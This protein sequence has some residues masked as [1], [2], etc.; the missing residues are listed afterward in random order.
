MTFTSLPSQSNADKHLT[1]FSP[2]V[3]ARLAAVASTQQVFLWA[4]L[5]A[6]AA[7]SDF[8]QGKVDCTTERQRRNLIESMT[9]V[10]V[11]GDS[12]DVAFLRAGGRALTSRGC[13]GWCEEALSKCPVEKISSAFQ[14]VHQMLPRHVTSGVVVRVLRRLSAAHRLDEMLAVWRAF[15]F[16]SSP[17]PQSTTKVVERLLLNSLPL[18][19]N[20]ASIRAARTGVQM[21]IEQAALDVLLGHAADGGAR[22]EA[23]AQALFVFSDCVP[24]KSSGIL[25]ACARWLS[26]DS[27]SVLQ[28]LLVRVLGFESGIS[29]ERKLLGQG[30]ETKDRSAIKADV[31]R[32][33]GALANASRIVGADTTRSKFSTASSINPHVALTKEHYRAKRA[34]TLGPQEKLLLLRVARTGDWSGALKH[35]CSHTAAEQHGL[36]GVQLCSE[37]VASRRSTSGWIGALQIA[38]HQLK[39]PESGRPIHHGLL[40]RVAAVV[41]DCGAWEGALAMLSS[42][43]EQCDCHVWSQVIHCLCKA[44]RHSLLMPMWAKWRSAVGDADAVPL[45]PVVVHALLWGVTHGSRGY[46]LFV[47]NVLLD[48]LAILS[49][50]ATGANVETSLSPFASNKRLS[51]F[52][53]NDHWPLSAENAIQIALYA[54][55]REAVETLLRDFGTA[56]TARQVQKY[57]G[58]MGQGSKM[59]ASIHEVVIRLLST[60]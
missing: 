21:S 58:A 36:F 30:P 60:Y 37:A 16:N 32:R 34:V 25:G 22:R 8:Q 40:P 39:R 19:I 20:P 53:C 33:Y 2:L 6:K 41:A 5:T 12:R 10:I 38:S 50:P 56:A 18:S 42:F 4:M 57:Y 44:R 47:A 7:K 35:L 3:R 17:K 46:D 59:P 26:P 29:F 14:F 1:M 51:N 11:T 24:A 23:L 45:H 9:R 43:Q 27:V 15:D 28:D 52:L 55:N 54:D 49:L 13:V 31:E 48:S